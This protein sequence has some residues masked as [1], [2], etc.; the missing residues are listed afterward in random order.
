[1]G[2]IHGQ[3]DGRKEGFVPGGSSLHNCM[4]PHGND[5]EV[6]EA[7]SNADL[8]PQYIKD[9]MAFMFETCL[10]YKPTKFAMETEH[11]QQDYSGCWQGLKKHF[12]GK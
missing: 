4:S 2:L 5:A 8:K 12:T 1:M 10:L 11:L 9:T 6:Y 7:A 3:Y